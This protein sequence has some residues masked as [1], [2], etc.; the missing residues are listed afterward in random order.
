MTAVEV[1]PDALLMDGEQWLSAEV[2]RDENEAAHEA[3]RQSDLQL[4][5]S[6]EATRLADVAV[7]DRVREAGV[8]ARYAIRGGRLDPR[9]RASETH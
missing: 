3:Q 4:A 8:S 7:M 2:R 1:S 9:W 5:A 6:S